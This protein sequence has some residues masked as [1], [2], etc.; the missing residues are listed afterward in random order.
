MKAIDTGVFYFYVG[1][2]LCIQ[3]T[4]DEPLETN[5]KRQFRQWNKAKISEKAERKEKDGK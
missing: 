5:R 4:G 1:K 2:G 3:N